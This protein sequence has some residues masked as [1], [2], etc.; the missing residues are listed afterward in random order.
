MAVPA[1]LPLGEECERKLYWLYRKLSPSAVLQVSLVHLGIFN[2]SYTGICVVV[3]IP[4]AYGLTHGVAVL[5]LLTTQRIFD[6]DMLCL[7]GCY[8][9]V[10][11]QV[12]MVMNGHASIDRTIEPAGTQQRR[13]KREACA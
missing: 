7:L 12:A 9:A 2:I 11:F 4:M 8:P 5:M 3:H 1:D 13:Q 10:V 6:G